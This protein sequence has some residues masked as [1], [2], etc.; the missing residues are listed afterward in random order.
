MNQIYL[1]F[2]LYHI[3][4]YS[5]SKV[6]NTYLYWE[7]KLLYKWHIRWKRG[8]YLFSSRGGWVLVR[9]VVR[10]SG[11][12]RKILGWKIK[13]KCSFAEGYSYMEYSRF[14]VLK[15]LVTKYI[16]KTSGEICFVK[17]RPPERFLYQYTCIYIMLYVYCVQSTKYYTLY[18]CVCIPG[19]LNL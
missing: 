12:A 8:K 17:K 10:S 11:Q 2:I 9:I 18:I 19:L 15:G 1:L 7:E 4:I 16:Y 6:S 3:H 14:V 13:S 5:Y